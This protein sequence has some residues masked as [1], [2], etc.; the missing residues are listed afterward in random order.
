MTV[1]PSTVNR[2]ELG[3]QEWQDTLFLNYGLDT[4][5]LHHYFDGCNSTFSICHAL[6]CK[7][8][9]IFTAC[10]NNLCDRVTDLASKDFIPSHVCNDPLIFACC[11]VKRPEEKSTRSKA[12]T[13]P[14]DRPPLEATEQKGDVLICDLWHNGTYSVHDMRVMNTDA[15]SHLENTPEK[16]LQEAEQEK[17]NM[18]LYAC[19]QQHRHFLPSL[20]LLMGCWGCGRRPP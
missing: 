6:D 9:G 20:P 13:V 3:S 10:H 11:A 18:Y 16:C 8:G 19:L 7:R 17:K 12:I 1:Q 4:P 5:D 15:K 14:A 2:T